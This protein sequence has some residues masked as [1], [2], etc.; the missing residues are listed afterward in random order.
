[1]VLLVVPDK[2]A[3]TYIWFQKN[4]FDFEN[5]LRFSSAYQNLVGILKMDYIVMVICVIIL[6]KEIQFIR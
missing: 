5:N 3:Q 2:C 1:M 4:L 6:V